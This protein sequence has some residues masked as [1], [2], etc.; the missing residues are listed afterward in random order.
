MNENHD[1]FFRDKLYDLESP[2]NERVSFEEV[3]ERRKKKRRFIFWWNPKVYVVA[4]LF[5]VGGLGMYL[6]NP[7]GKHQV[8]VSTK[9]LTSK[10]VSANASKNSKSESKEFKEN[11]HNEHSQE[12]A[13]ATSKRIDQ[14]QQNHLTI[15][16]KELSNSDKSAQ[17]KSNFDGDRAESNLGAVSLKR[18]QA[19]RGYSLLSE[20]QNGIFENQIFETSKEYLK[21]SHSKSATLEDFLIGKSNN[22]ADKNYTWNNQNEMVRSLALNHLKIQYPEFDWASFNIDLDIPDRPILPKMPNSKWY[23][24]L[25]VITGSNNT[26]NFEEDVPLSVLGTQYMAQYQMLLL[27]DLENGSMLGAGVQYSEW[28]GNGQWQLNKNE[29]IQHI[30]THMVLVSAPWQPKK[31]ARFIDTTYVPANNVQTGNIEYRIGKISF[32]L[33]YRF[34]TQI[35]KTPL[36]VGFHLAPG[37]TTVNSGTYF[38]TTDYR[39]I[40][41]ARHMTID[42]KLSIGPMIP[43]T[44][45]WTFVIEPSLMYQSFLTDNNST[46]NGKFFTGLGIAI[47]RKL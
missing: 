46:V 43:V 47:L 29:M 2:L 35:A 6:A 37:Y 19:R 11:L 38:T 36:R 3:M 39:P 21:L 10:V 18:K 33:A 31:Y 8:P 20:N 44:K 40:D 32:P 13:A 41:K 25:S 26:I 42:G 16:R 9:D 24:E 23:A 4:G 15:E 34:Y 12:L 17:F 7:F 5:V 22:L 28:V 27:K 14:V 1:S 30:D 45:K